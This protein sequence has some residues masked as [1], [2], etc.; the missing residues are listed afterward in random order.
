[1]ATTSELLDLLEDQYKG[2][3]R[4]GPRGLLRYLD[5][6]QKILCHVPAQQ[7]LIVEQANGKLRTFP[8]TANI[9][10]YDMQDDVAFVE[11]LLV[12][13]DTSSQILDY[14]NVQDYG[15]ISPHSTKPKYPTISGIKYVHIPY[16]RSWPAGESHPARVMFTVNPGTTTDTYRVRA[17]RKPA[18]LDSD[19]IELTIEPPYDEVYLLPAACKL[20]EG[21]NNGNYIEARSTII[22]EYRPL[23]HKAFNE[24]AQG[25]DYETDPLGF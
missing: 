9:Y 20:I 14:M 6:A 17:Y 25:V 3:V 18:S 11:E 7:L 4:D 8:T 23:M 19:S 12:E 2:W 21:V 22:R 13:A 1:M 24:G 5:A 16:V 10:R 15:R